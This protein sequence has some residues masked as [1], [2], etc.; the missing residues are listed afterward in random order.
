M[1][2]DNEEFHPNDR[3]RLKNM[4]EPFV[5]DTPRFVVLC[6]YGKG[7]PVEGK[8]MCQRY[9]YLNILEPLKC[10]LYK[11]HSQQQS[12]ELI[13]L[14]AEIMKENFGKDWNIS[15]KDKYLFPAELLEHD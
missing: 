5:S 6:Q 15:F 12:N 9:T 7:S 11:M 1:D 2:K 4:G 14:F 8:V 3:V 13:T 10:E